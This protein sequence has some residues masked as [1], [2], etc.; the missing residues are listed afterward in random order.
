VI[1]DVKTGQVLAFA[2]SPTFDPN[3]RELS[4]PDTYG[5]EALQDVYEPGSVEKVLTFSALI[6]AGYASQ[7]TGYYSGDFNFSGGSPNS[8]DYFLI[9]KAY[10]GQGAP[11]SGASAAEASP[12]PASSTEIAPAPEV[13]DAESAAGSDVGSASA[14]APVITTAVSTSTEFETTKKTRRHRHH[15]APAREFAAEKKSQDRWL[16]PST[17]SRR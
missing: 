5:S 4:S 15:R 17:F 8:D 6:D 10:S 14:D 1:Q 11:L 2:D 12:Q 13:V 16:M 3:K 7:A 9:D